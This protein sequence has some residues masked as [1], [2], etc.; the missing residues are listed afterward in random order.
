MSE[1]TSK[2]LR[3]SNPLCSGER[4]VILQI[5]TSDMVGVRNWLVPYEKAPKPIG[6]LKAKQAGKAEEE[7]SVTVSEIGNI[8]GMTLT[9]CLTV[10]RRLPDGKF[11]AVLT[12]SVSTNS[13]L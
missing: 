10:D 11:D 12:F 6:R 7:F 9:P 13:V 1:S 3:V 2:V 8:A 5:I 4:N